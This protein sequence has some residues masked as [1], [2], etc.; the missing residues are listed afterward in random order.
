M[1]NI[2]SEK[3]ILLNLLTNYWFTIPEY[4]RSY[5]WQEDNVQE[6]LDDVWSA[7]LEDGQSEYFLGSLVLQQDDKINNYF[8]VLDG[9]QRLTTIILTLSVIKNI[10][11]EKNDII[12][13]ERNDLLSTIKEVLYQ[14]E[15][16]FRNIKERVRIIFKIRDNVNDFVKNFILPD[17]NT[18][19]NIES[20]IIK[21]ADQTDNVSISNMADA[22]ITIKTFLINK[23][24]QQ[25]IDFCKY[26]F[27]KIVFIYVSTAKFEDAYRLFTIINNRGIPLTHSDII[28]S[29]NIGLIDDQ[30]KEKY[31]KEWE[32]IET[33][34]NANNFEGGFDR[35]LSHLRFVILKTK[36]RKSLLDEF[37]ENIYKTGKLKK[38]VDTIKFIKKFK[39][40]Y[41]EIIKLK[42]NSVDNNFKNLVTI[43]IEGIPS[44]E[45]MAALMKYYD[46]FN[47][48]KIY[49]FLKLLEYK[50]SGDWIIDENPTARI[51][52]LANILSAIENS[53][54]PEILLQDKTI[55]NVD[56]TELHNKL[57]GNVYARKFSKYILLKLEYI[58]A[59]NTIHF[60]NFKHI[61]VEHILPQKPD[62]NSMWVKIF[63]ENERE[64]WTHKLANL[65]LINRIKNSSL[66]R[67]DYHAKKAK[68]FD[69]HIS[70]FPRSCKLINQYNEWNT[71][72]L[73][74]IQSELLNKLI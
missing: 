3:I 17:N 46:K 45:W 23:T 44:T 24:T 62:D 74:N 31:S 65:I 11:L 12:Q 60:S 43:M 61:S 2:N 30:S 1:K 35:F 53:A 69:K 13:K 72:I 73:K 58:M 28:K 67:L 9:Q 55:F 48:N 50:F 52:N 38:G 27:N 33:D 26:F 54:S 22:M 47:N 21:L 5:V 16:Q 10:I 34:F 39:S 42:S 66:G 56:K 19:Q 59:D 36:A 40:Y 6:L 64:F 18:F 71:L 57:D 25:L 20:D 41:D 4:Q 68:Y 49:E 63:N 29:I 7:F 70:I 15:N 8:D 32:E 51:N 37:E 14:G